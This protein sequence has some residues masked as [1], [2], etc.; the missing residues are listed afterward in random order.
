MYSSLDFQIR[1]YYCFEN[2]ILCKFFCTEKN[3]PELKATK[4]AVFFSGGLA[5]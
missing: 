1:K 3:P 2:F 4:L 5:A